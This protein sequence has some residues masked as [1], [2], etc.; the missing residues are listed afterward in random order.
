[1]EKKT[2]RFYERKLPDANEI[3]MVK[4]MAITDI[5]VNVILPEYNNIEGLMLLNELSRKR[6]RSV[7]KFV[8]IGVTEPSMVIRVDTAK[9]YVDLSKKRVTAEDVTACL[10]RYHKAKLV[11]SILKR[12]AETYDYPLEK[13]YEQTAWPLDKVYGSSYIGF[14]GILTHPDDVSE[15][16]S[17]D[18]PVDIKQSLIQ[19]ICRRLASQSIKVCAYID[20]TC[21]QHGIDAIKDALQQG[22][23]INDK[24]AINLV[25]SPTYTIT[26]TAV[27][28]ITGIDVIHKAIDAIKT[29][30][31]RYDGR[32][33]IRQSPRGIGSQEKTWM[34]QAQALATANGEPFVDSQDDDD[35][36][37][38]N[39]VIID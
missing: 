14:R 18:L 9:G 19:S 39:D 15:N 2:Y 29:C 25:A 10:A 37:D 33:E 13:L 11:D 26:I 8:R 24:I 32:L 28:E 5:G 35:D 22:L 3:V 27:D 31:E 21:Y 1:M 17:Q 36:S 6:V 4:I 38:K 34:E 16:W 7:H 23:D 20:I 12:V 30:I